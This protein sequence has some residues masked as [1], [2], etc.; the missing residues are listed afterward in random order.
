MNSKAL[1][2]KAPNSNAFQAMLG[3][4]DHRTTLRLRTVLGILARAAL[5]AADAREEPDPAPCVPADLT[6]AHGGPAAEGS[7]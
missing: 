6:S 4:N 7:E 1:T 3:S 5:R 2:H